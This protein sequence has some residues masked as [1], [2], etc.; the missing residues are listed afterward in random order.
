MAKNNKQ[1]KH[2]EALLAC[3]PAT[4]L[5]LAHVLGLT[6]ESARSALYTL[7]RRGL[8]HRTGKDHRTIRWAVGKRPKA[9]PTAATFLPKPSRLKADPFEVVRTF[10][11]DFFSGNAVIHLLKTAGQPS[12]SDL[13]KAR[14]FINQILGDS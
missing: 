10:G 12:R 9:P 3:L 5:E 4:T 6:Q 2:R 7:E 14:E 13:I 11:L 1:L 8:V